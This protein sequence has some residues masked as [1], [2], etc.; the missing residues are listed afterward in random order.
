[1]PLPLLIGGLIT[2]LI[3]TAITAGVIGCIVAVVTLLTKSKLKEIIRNKGYD[4]CKIKDMYR[5]RDYECVDVG[6]YVD[7]DYVGDT[8]I[9]AEDIA[10]DIY[11]GQVLYV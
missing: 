8:T 11:E 6:L 9:K 3:K 2:V 10:E 7:N 1:M 5:S 4:K